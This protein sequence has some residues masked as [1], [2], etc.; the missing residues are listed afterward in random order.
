MNIF[1]SKMIDIQDQIDNILWNVHMNNL[2]RI[3]KLHYFLNKIEWD[4]FVDFDDTI[5]DNKCLL[6][7]KYNY[8]KKKHKLNEDKLI[9]DFI[10]NKKF[11]LFF[12]NKKGSNILILSANNLFFLKKIIKKNKDFFDELWVKIIWIV[13]STDFLKINL[14][15]K[16][17]LI[18]EWKNYVSDIMECLTFRGNDNYICLDDYSFLNFVGI[19][20]RKIYYY[21]LFIIKNA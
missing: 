4:F 14:E 21:L 6:Y 1:Y 10:V 7:S 17:K 5:S 3:E 9:G 20:L 13:W 11:E 12:S 19:F 8:L 18:P 15:V 2:E 16:K